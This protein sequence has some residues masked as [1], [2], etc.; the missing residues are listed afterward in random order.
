MSTSRPPEE[1]GEAPGPSSTHR[2]WPWFYATLGLIVVAAVVGASLLRPATHPAQKHPRAPDPKTGEPGDHWYTAFGVN[3]CGEWLPSP[4]T[5]ETAAGNPNVR[6]GIN[7]HG[8]GYVHTHPEDSSEAGNHADPR[9]VLQLR[10]LAGVE[11]VD[12]RV[13]RPGRRPREAVL[14]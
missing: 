13:D 1:G 4:P 6:I 9:P 3:V 11:H 5:F 7:T 8:D 12:R 14:A 10:R 2:R